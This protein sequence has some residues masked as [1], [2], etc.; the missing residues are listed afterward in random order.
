MDSRSKFHMLAMRELYAEDFSPR[1]GK[2]ALGD[3]EKDMPHPSYDLGRNVQTNGRGGDLTCHGR[4]LVRVLCRFSAI[5]D[6]I[7][8]GD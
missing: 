8:I 4:V 2:A 7:L 5:F 3:C 1:V 6:R